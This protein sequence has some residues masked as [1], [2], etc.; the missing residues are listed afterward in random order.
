MWTQEVTDRAVALWKSGF[1]A[2]E[3]GEAIG[4][5]RNAVIGKMNRLG[6]GRAA[7]IHPA[8]KRK[9][10]PI[11]RVAKPRGPGKRELKRLA[12]VKAKREHEA[13]RQQVIEALAIEFEALTRSTCRF[14]VNEPRKG[15]RH[16][17][18]GHPV[19]PGKVYCPHHCA[20]AYRVREVKE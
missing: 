15:E 6:H 11:V 2:R 3:V 8:T 13:M 16:L 18:C 14:P 19:A 9:G 5:T 7:P 10:K 20:V 4:F 12:L 1:S 17:F